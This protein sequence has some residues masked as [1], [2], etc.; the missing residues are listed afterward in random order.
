M[1]MMKRFVGMAALCAAG[2]ASATEARA[3]GTAAPIS[4]KLFAAA[5]AGAGMS[6]VAMG[7]LA[8]QRGADSETKTFAQTMVADHSKANKELMALAGAK[9]IPLP[10]TL[11]VQDQAAAEVLGGLQGEMFDREYAKQQLAAHLCAVQLF[12]AEA[13]RGQDPDLKAFAAKTLPHLKQ[14]LMTV[15]KLAKL[16]MDRS[17]ESHK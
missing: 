12:H 16:E 9:G 14:H 1:M 10:A 13:T 8:L 17:T 3:Q 11:P 5:A 2:F 7:E 15:H 4:D 6:E